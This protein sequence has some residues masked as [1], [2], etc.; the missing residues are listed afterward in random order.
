MSEPYGHPP[1]PSGAVATA[2]E[3][4]ANI[5]I[6][7]GEDRQ[8]IPFSLVNLPPDTSDFAYGQVAQLVTDRW[9]NDRQ[10]SYDWLV[11]PDRAKHIFLAMRQGKV[12]SRLMCNGQG[13]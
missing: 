5:I 9:R 3:Q 1:V 13:Y 8:E 10:S 4:L 2:A 7:S 12:V 11:A 6:A